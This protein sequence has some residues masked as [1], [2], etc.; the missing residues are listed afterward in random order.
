MLTGLDTVIGGGTADAQAA[1]AKAAALELDGCR[2]GAIDALREAQGTGD[3]AVLFRL[4]YLL[5]L[6]GEEDEALSLY[7]QCA[8]M[9]RPS[10]N[11]LLNLAVM[12]EDR[13]D[14]GSAEKCLRQI[15]DTN[16]TNTRARLFMRDVLASKDMYYDEEHARDMAKRNA[17]LDTPVTDFELS[18]RARNCLKKMSIRTLGDLLRVSESELLSYKNF[19]ETSLVEIKAMLTA[20]GLR[21]GQNLENQYHRVRADVYEELRG[22]AP[23]A[24]LN[25]PV[26]QMDFS[27]R[28]RKA[29][30]MLGIMSVGDLATRTE[31]ELMGIKNFGMTSL[32]EIKERLASFGLELRTL[33]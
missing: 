26:T 18:V 14:Y 4:A 3:D 1:L 21:L 16:P 9:D 19:G 5:D 15:L 22:R 6:V 11:V 17:L 23:E 24:V 8:A 10:V 27:V 13:S 33:D 25:K 12:Y 7:Q 31:A 32:D 2:I 29:L 20:K 28:A 30:Q